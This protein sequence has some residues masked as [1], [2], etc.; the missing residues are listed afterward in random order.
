MIGALKIVADVTQ[1][2]VTE[3]MLSMVLML[4]GTHSI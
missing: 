1:D 2:G 4:P 3:V